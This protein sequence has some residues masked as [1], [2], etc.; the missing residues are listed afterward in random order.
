MEASPFLHGFPME[1]WWPR[2]TIRFRDSPARRLA[3]DPQ[4]ATPGDRLWDGRPAR[5]VVYDPRSCRT[6][7][8]TPTPVRLSTAA[9][10][11]GASGRLTDL[12]FYLS[13][14]EGRQRWKS[15]L[16]AGASP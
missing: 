5:R 11:S 12:V 16:H 9:R 3:G 1:D 13:G 15:P 10:V 8:R 2:R 6:M 7:S 4:W 14:M